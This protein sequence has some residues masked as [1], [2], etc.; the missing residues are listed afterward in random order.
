MQ[1]AVIILMALA[2]VMSY[3]VYM[4]PYEFVF[5][6]CDAALGTMNNRDKFP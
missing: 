4:I 3:A 6:M 1:V 5:W 2:C